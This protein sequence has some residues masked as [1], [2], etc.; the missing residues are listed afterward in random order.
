M[1]L[2]PHPTLLVAVLPVGREMEGNANFVVV[3][4]VF[5]QQTMYTFGLDWL[6]PSCDAGSTLTHYVPGASLYRSS[7][8][9]SWNDVPLLYCSAGIGKFVNVACSTSSIGSE[10]AAYLPFR[11]SFSSDD[12]VTLGCGSSSAVV[13]AYRDNVKFAEGTIR[14]EVSSTCSSSGGTMVCDV[15]TDFAVGRFVLAVECASRRVPFVIGFSKKPLPGLLCSRTD[16]T[17]TGG[18]IT[19][20]TAASM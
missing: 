15:S 10:C 18:V 9:Q 17:C 11:L 4:N 3:G 19:G 8:A 6:N 2:E 20:G 14:K 12:T 16:I 5:P 7:F 1:W 13:K